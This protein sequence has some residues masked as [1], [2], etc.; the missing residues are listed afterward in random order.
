MKT[1]LKVPVSLEFFPPKTTEGAEKLRAVRAQLYALK[2]EFCSVTYGAGGSTQAGTFA[3]VNEILAEGLAAA[4]HFSCIG[5]TRDS[6]R[7]ELQTLKA[8]GVKRLVA[9]R[10]DLPSG[11]GAGGEFTYA[12]DLVAFIRAETGRD[13]HIEVAAYPEIHPQAKS[14]EADIQAFVTK[15]QAGA[16]SAITQ[17]FYNSDAYFRFVDDVYKRGVD[18]PIVPGIMPITSSTQ[19]LR[20][21]DACGAEIPRW[22]RLRLQSFGDDTASIKAFG[23]DVVADLCEQLCNGGAPALHFYSMNQSAATLEI[24]SRL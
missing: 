7:A 9:L 14:A 11:Y 3:T 13:F 23:L 19:L 10:G 8:M 22:I 17:Y 12:S 4:S 2:P 18:V 6:V 21:S 5:A 15:V 1:S 20:F 16:D 24:A